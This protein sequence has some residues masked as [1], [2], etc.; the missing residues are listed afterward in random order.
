MKHFASYTW[1]LAPHEQPSIT[2]HQQDNSVSFHRADYGAGEAGFCLRF[3]AAHL[4]ALR[5]L[6]HALEE[7][8]YLQG[9]PPAGV[10]EVDLF[11]V[12]VRENGGSHGA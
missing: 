9:R 7:V 11:N 3:S 2:V 12:A 5:K 10:A 1:E 6:V 8:E 4:P